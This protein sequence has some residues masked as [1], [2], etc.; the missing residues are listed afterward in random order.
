MAALEIRD[1][2]VRYE[3]STGIVE[4]LSN[5]NLAMGNGDLT[6]ALGASGCG[7]TTL[8]S[9]IAGFLAPS[10]GSVLLDGRAVTGPGADRGVVF[11][12]HALMPWLSVL[13]NVTSGTRLPARS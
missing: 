1:L 13:D 9:V 12:R 3:S 7:K 8:L 10:H 5:V 6:V 2:S 4:A 11:Q